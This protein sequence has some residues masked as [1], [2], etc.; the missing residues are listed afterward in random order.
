MVAAQA[1]RTPLSDS[2][3]ELID[4]ALRIGT[5]IDIVAEIDFERVFD[6][7]SLEIVLDVSDGFSKKISPAVNVADGVDTRIRRQ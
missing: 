1:N 3:G 5:P 2:D 4:H 7:P 6:R